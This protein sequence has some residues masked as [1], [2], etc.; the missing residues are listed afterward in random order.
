[1]VTDSS[2]PFSIASLMIY[3]IIQEVSQI[4]LSN[5][6]NKPKLSFY[7]A[8]IAFLFPC[9]AVFISSLKC[10]N[11]MKVFNPVQ[12][13]R[14][15]CFLFYSTEL[16]HTPLYKSII[17]VI[18]ADRPRKLGHRVPWWP[19]S[20]SRQRAHSASCLCWESRI[21]VASS[22]R[23]ACP[24]WANHLKIIILLNGSMQRVWLDRT[25]VCEYMEE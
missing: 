5:I 4:S 19:W 1:M 15:F 8:C 21:A 17:L 16:A 9:R 20:Q 12:I 18:T 6:F 11:E 22:C 10:S 25:D 13:S 23:Q 7:R 2:A 14:S 24:S 3:V